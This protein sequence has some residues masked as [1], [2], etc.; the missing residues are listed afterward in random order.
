MELSRKT[1]TF[2]KLTYSISETA[3][4]LG[5]SRPTIYKLIHQA[6]FPV[7]SVGTRQLVSVEGLRRWVEGKAGG[8]NNGY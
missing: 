3:A 8:G 4:V 7:F 2:E 1:Q 5:V 6:G